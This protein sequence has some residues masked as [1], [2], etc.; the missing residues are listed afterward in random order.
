LKGKKAVDI[1]SLPIKPEEQVM[2]V[3]FSGHPVAGFD[4]APFVGV[5]LPLEAKPLVE[6]IH[7]ALLALPDRQ[8]LLQGAQAE[9]ILPG[10]SGA[11]GV[12]LAEWHGLFGSFPTIR[13]AIKG[14]NGFAWPEE[15]RADL[16]VI[17]L[18]ARTMR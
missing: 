16:Q 7:K 11:A 2:K 6:Q 14:P 17:R 9:I 1:S 15:G 8:A 5:N 4:V 10:M 3:N 18:D 13:W 12:L